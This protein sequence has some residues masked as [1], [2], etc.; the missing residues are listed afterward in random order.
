MFFLIHSMI[1]PAFL[2]TR[3]HYW[4]MVNLLSTRTPRSFSVEIFFP[5]GQLLTYTDRCSYSSRGTG[6]LALVKSHKVPP[7]PTLQSDDSSEADIPEMRCNTMQKTFLLHISPVICSAFDHLIRKG[8][9]H[10]FYFLTFAFLLLGAEVPAFSSFP[11]KSTAFECSWF[12][13]LL[14]LFQLNLQLS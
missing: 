3:T 5:S 9:S 6:F 10:S 13:L 4:L 7:H 14:N 8:M 12:K 1:P 2:V 11:I